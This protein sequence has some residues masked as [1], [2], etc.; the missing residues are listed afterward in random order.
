[1]KKVLLMAVCL[2]LT[3]AAFGQYFS[4]RLDSQPQVYHVPEHPQH[5]GY[6]SLG[7]GVGIVGGGSVNFAQGE[8]PVSD[9]PQAAAKPLGDAAREL[10][11]EHA[12]LKK[13]RF[14]WEN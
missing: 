4:S 9:F 5:A 11:K 10:K 2:I 6:T 7:Q 8:R 3:N 12:A 13:S 14:V 1:M